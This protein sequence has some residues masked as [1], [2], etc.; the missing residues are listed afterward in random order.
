M[1]TLTITL[2]KKEFQKVK[3]RARQEGFKAPAAW[4]QFLVEI[5]IGFEES[6]KLKPPKIIS[7]MKKTGLYKAQFL[8]ALEKSLDYAN[9][10]SQFAS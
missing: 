8:R 2:P 1:P 10:A 3:E 6:S 7:E 5:N 4:A 9:K